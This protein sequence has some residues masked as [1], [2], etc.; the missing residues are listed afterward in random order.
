M[1]CTH[2][3]KAAKPALAKQLSRLPCLVVSENAF[4]EFPGV[5]SIF[6][7]NLPLRCLDLFP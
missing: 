3:P 7:A 1:S 5:S 6:L 4:D 2:L